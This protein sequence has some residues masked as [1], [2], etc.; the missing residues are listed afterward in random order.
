MLFNCIKYPC[1]ANTTRANICKLE[2]FKIRR[3]AFLNYLKF[4]DRHQL[5]LRK[6]R[7]GETPLFFPFAS[8]AIL[9]KLSYPDRPFHNFL[10]L[11]IHRS[12]NFTLFGNVNRRIVRLSNYEWVNRVF[13][14][15]YLN[16]FLVFLVTSDLQRK[17]NRMKGGNRAAFF[18]ISLSLFLFLFLAVTKLVCIC[19]CMISR[20]FEASYNF[21]TSWTL[22]WPR[23]LKHLNR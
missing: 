6:V 12:I 4:L 15:F 10:S 7:S 19:S 2:S 14:S 1:E 17:E 20:V 22:L 23:Q 16:F 21:P 9:L 13:P 8:V 5:N 18:C 3:S 11:K